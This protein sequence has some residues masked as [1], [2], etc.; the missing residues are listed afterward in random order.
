MSITHDTTTVNQ[1]FLQLLEQATATAASR[2][3]CPEFSDEVW[4]QMGVGRVLEATESG[5]A[6]LREHGL[7]FK[8]PPRYN[9]YFASLKSER[10]RDLA[11]EVNQDLIGRVQARVCDRLADIPEL[12]RYAAFAA[13]GHWHKAA[14]HDPKHEGRKM[15]VG[16]F[17]AL[18]LRPHTLRH[19]AA[20]Q[21]LHEH[22]LSALKR[23]K[24]GGLRQGTPQGTRGL[25]I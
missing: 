18:N 20:G 15:A 2:R 14:V 24:P 16:H 19:L 17:Y 1:Q 6:F 23:L 25:I 7:R 5:R 22:D 3:P 9:N 8:N 21:G 4:V 12:A 10:R 11:R 13:D